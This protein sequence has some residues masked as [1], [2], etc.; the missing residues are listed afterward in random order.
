MLQRRQSVVQILLHF[1]MSYQSDNSAHRLYGLD[2]QDRK[3]SSHN[4][5]NL[6]PLRQ[7]VQGDQEPQRLLP[8]LAKSS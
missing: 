3:F 5:R 6:N 8:P 4:L 1:V 7:A 2:H